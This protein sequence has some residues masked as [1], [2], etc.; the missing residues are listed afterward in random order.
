MD[1]ADVGTRKSKT[2]LA[3]E[4]IICILAYGLIWAFAFCFFWF[5]VN[6]SVED[7]SPLGHLGQFFLSLA[8]NTLCP[9][10]PFLLCGVLLGAFTCLSAAKFSGAVWSSLIWSLI[11]V[12]IVCVFFNFTLSAFLPAL[13]A[14]SSSLIAGSIIARTWQQTL[15]ALPFAGRPFV[16]KRVVT[17][18]IWLLVLSVPFRLFEWAGVLG[19]RAWAL[20]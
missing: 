9:D 11:P 14:V 2:A 3:R 20:R 7:F 4:Q 17:V 1:E 6:I 10:W 18:A 19:R 15:F 12:G 16:A 8:W 13:A 5:L